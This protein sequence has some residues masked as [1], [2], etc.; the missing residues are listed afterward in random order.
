[1]C[2]NLNR[3]VFFIRINS[4]IS[5]SL[6]RSSQYRILRI[7]IQGNEPLGIQT[8]FNSINQSEIIK[9][10]N[11]GPVIKYNDNPIWIN[12][13]LIIARYT[14]LSFVNFTALT[15]VL[16][17]NSPMHLKDKSSHKK[18]LFLGN[19]GLSPPPTKANILVLNII[20]TMPMP[21]LSSININVN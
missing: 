16:K 7:R 13:L 11:I 4:N 21:P 10:I 12:I 20:S 8:S 17:L 15:F 9:I 6:I 3:F 5:Q 1:M 18:T 19:L 2:W 14:Y